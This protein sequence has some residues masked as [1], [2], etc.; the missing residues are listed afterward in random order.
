MTSFKE[1]GFV[2]TKNMFKQAYD[3][4]Y[5]VPAFNFVTLEQLLARDQMVYRFLKKN[6]VPA[7]FLMAGGYGEEVWQVYAQFLSWVLPR[8]GFGR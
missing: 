4:G 8:E 1:L 6:R 3:Q 2:N 7:A 5:A